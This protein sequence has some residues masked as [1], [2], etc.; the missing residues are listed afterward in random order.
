MGKGA[1]NPS[2]LS[3]DR[4]KMTNIAVAIGLDE[5][6]WRSVPKIAGDVQPVGNTVRS[7]CRSQEDGRKSAALLL[8]PGEQ[9]LQVAGELAGPDLTLDAGFADLFFP[10]EE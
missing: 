5:R 6:C 8:E 10:A 4:G 7:G 3:I 1:V 9:F 2:Q